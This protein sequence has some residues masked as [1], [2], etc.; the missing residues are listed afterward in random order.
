LGGDCH[1]EYNNAN[2]F[3]IARQ[4]RK[5][6]P[7]IILAPHLD[8][9]QHPDH[10][11]LGRLTRDAARFA[12]YGGLEELKDLPAHSIDSLYYY[13]VTQQFSANPDIVIDISEVKEQWVKVM[14]CHKTQIK[15]KKYVDLWLSSARALGNAVKVDYALGLYANDPIMLNNLSDI[16]LSSRNY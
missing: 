14:E 3:I 10:F 15:S 4:I 16:T 5:F 7:S 8:E 6:K 13:R 11:R 9:N 1:I 2:A 12:R